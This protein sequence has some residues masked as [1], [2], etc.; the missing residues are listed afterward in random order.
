M[1]TSSKR[2]REEGDEEDNEAVGDAL[3]PANQAPESNRCLLHLS[4]CAHPT[5]KDILNG[6]YEENRPHHGRSTYKKI[7]SGNWDPLYV[8]YWYDK[9]AISFLQV[10]KGE[11]SPSAN[12]YR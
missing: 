4:G 8:Y 6:Y 3:L 9:K 2:R 1:D 7:G 11:K 12:V 10:T 5:V